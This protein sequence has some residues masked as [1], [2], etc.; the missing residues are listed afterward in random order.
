M[1]AIIG[2]YPKKG[3]PR[4]STVMIERDDLFNLD[5][6]LAL[7]ILPA[8]K[9]FREELVCR[10]SN[11]SMKQWEGIIDKMIAAFQTILEEKE[12]NCLN[13]EVAKGLRLFAKYY[14]HLWL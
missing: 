9:A 10:P 13:E 14:R 11:L 4:P 3:G 8:L 1:K 2:K 6:T 5:T 7:I 12:E